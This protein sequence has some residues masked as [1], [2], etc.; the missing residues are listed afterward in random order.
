MAIVS[1]ESSIV[2]KFRTLLTEDVRV[3]IYNCHMIIVQ[4]TGPVVKKFYKN[5]PNPGFYGII[6]L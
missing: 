1:D 3:V 2:N 4:T 5:C 6:L